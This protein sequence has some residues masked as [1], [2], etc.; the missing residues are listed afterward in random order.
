MMSL[1]SHIKPV[2]DVRE[3][4]RKLKEDISTLKQEMANLVQALKSRVEAT[5]CFND[6]LYIILTLVV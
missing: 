3:E 6:L 4:M 5:A 2:E 1:V